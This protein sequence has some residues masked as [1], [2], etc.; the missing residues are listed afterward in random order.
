MS[1]ATRL[2]LTVG[3]LLW[4]PVEGHAQVPAKVDRVH[5]SFGG[6][7]VA[8]NSE[9]RDTLGGG[10]NLTLGIQ[11]DATPII[12]VEGLLSTNDFG[13]KRIT[14]PV[15]AVPPAP[16][17]PMAFS[18][19]MSM[20]F[21]AGNLIVQKPVGRVRPYGLVGVGIYDRP[22]RLTTSAVGWV[23]GY[24]DPWF[25]VCYSGFVPVQNIVGERGSTDVGMAGGGGVNIGFVFL[26]LRYHYVWGPKIEVIQV[27]PFAG[28]PEP[29][30]A[31]GEFIAITFGLRF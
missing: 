22:T 14:I 2:A 17:V 30:K 27:I 28:A 21:A 6:G 16:L 24:C 1:T 11:F 31:D 15:S 7:Y 3:L 4:W 20:Q 19:M 5:F 12:S 13:S 10:Y 29:Q 23:P 8:P 25:Y 26:E 9:V 18:A